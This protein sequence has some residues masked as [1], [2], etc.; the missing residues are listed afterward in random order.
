MNQKTIGRLPGITSLLL[1]RAGST[2]LPLMLAA[3]AVLAAPLRADVA[4]ALN[5]P[6][7]TFTPSTRPFSPNG[8]LEDAA[9]NHDGEAA[10]RSGTTPANQNSTL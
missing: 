1:H 10:A 7:K 8:W 2:L 4:G 5:N 9:V 3:L 6:A